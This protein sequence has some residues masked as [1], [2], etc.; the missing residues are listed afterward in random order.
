MYITASFPLNEIPDQ[1]IVGDDMEYNGYINKP[2]TPGQQYAIY[3][4]VAVYTTGVE[5]ILLTDEPITSFKDG[6]LIEPTP[7]QN[8]AI[9]GATVSV[10]M[11]LIVIAGILA[12]IFI[13]RRRQ[14]KQKRSNEH[15][16]SGRNVP[17]ENTYA[18]VEDNITSSERDNITPITDKETGESQYMNITEAKKAPDV[19]KPDKPIKPTE[20]PT[21]ELTKPRGLPP[22]PKPKA[23]P[24]YNSQYTIQVK[25]LADYVIKKREENDFV[26]EFKLLPQSKKMEIPHEAASIPENKSK[27]RFHNVLSYDH[28]RVVLDVINDDPN[29]DYINANY[30]DGY[31][32]NNAYIATQGTNDI[33]IKD[34]WRMVLKENVATILMATNLSEGGKIKCIQYWPDKGSKKYGSIS[35]TLVKS[36]QFPDYFLRTIIV[37]QV[38]V[39][40]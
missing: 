32:K 17:S 4:G 1:L 23:K 19:V 35:V 11:V 20:V 18:N 5:E 27:N 10:I 3:D 21:S 40:C 7:R 6:V 26:A 38:C 12:A 31:Q 33:T 8:D 16:A 9:V 37:K 30:I 13:I 25:D 22:K 28:S 15:E 29:S 14:R 36:E 34:F 2:L 24:I 39:H